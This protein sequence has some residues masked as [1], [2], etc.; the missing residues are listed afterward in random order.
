MKF[1]FFIELMITTPL[2]KFTRG[3]IEYDEWDRSKETPNCI[4]MATN[5]YLSKCTNQIQ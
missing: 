3:L 1:N 4:K 2:W 5:D